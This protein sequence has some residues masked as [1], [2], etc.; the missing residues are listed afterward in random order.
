MFNRNYAIP[1]FKT[2]ICQ[3]DLPHMGSG[4]VMCADLFVDFGAI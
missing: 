3:K 4:V 1:L 2:V